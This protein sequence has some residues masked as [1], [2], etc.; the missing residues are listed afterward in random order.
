MTMGRDTVDQNGRI[1]RVLLDSNIWRY[2]VDAGAQ[3]KLLSAARDRRVSVQIAPAVVYEALRLRDV[4]LRNRLIALMTNRRFKRLMP[5]AY[6]EAMEILGE[7]RRLRPDWLRS[8]PDKD[9][10]VRSRNDWSRKTGGFWVRCSRSPGEEAQRLQTLEGSLLKQAAEQIKGARKEMMGV[11]WKANPSMD[12]TF[13]ALPHP[14]S[15]WN[16]E[17]VEAW[18]VESW[19]GVTYALSRPG[20]PYRDWIAPFVEIDDG[21]LN[22]S[23]WVEFW[24]HLASREALSR[25]WLRW[26]HSFAQRFRKVT[27]GSGADNQLFTYLLETDVVITADKTFF[28]ILEECR[29]FSPHPLPIGRLVPAGAPGVAST[30][31]FLT[32][33]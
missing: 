1:S 31:D 20:N 25:Q 12:K 30:L 13:A 7:V 16:G 27:D 26:A 23:A 29:P 3:G 28:D 22:S 11:G 17:R 21:L 24:L 14:V 4:P 6:S 32:G 18:R 10:F 15:G 9:F 2:V 5:E 19:A 8:E 33:K